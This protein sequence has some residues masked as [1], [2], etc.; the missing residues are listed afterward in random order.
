M[1]NL[2]LT[3]ANYCIEKKEKI[4]AVKRAKEYSKSIRIRKASLVKESLLTL[5]TVVMVNATFV[6]VL[7]D[8]FL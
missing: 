2:D 3:C 1:K 4:A 8:A 5:A 7:I 6:Y